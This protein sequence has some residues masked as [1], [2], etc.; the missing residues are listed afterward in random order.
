MAQVRRVRETV[1]T[2][3]DK[4][5]PQAYGSYT[6]WAKEVYCHYYNYTT[7]GLKCFGLIV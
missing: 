3:E 4:R 2:E 6:M 1:D 7:G 5:E